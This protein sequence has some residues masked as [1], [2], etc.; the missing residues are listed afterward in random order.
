MFNISNLVESE[1]KEPKFLHPVKLNYNQNGADKSWEVVKSHD[2]VAILIYHTEKRAFI[3]VKQFRPPVYLNDN[4]YNY[5][6]ELC[7]GLIDKEK[8]IEV[9]AKE[10]IEE[11]CG[12]RVDTDKIEKVTSFFTNVGVS[13]GRQHLFYVEVDD[14]MKIGDG[15]GVND[16]EIILEYLPLEKAKEFVFNE[17]IAKTPGLMFAFYWFFER[18]S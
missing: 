3:L 7:A 18:N 2:S 15:G 5:T 9:I 14:S 10:E 11:E 16:E 6:A 8:S 12:Y 17:N 4:R 13:G 1:L